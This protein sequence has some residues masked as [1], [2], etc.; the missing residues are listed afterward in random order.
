MPRSESFDKYIA[1]QMK[2]LDF[3]RLSLITSM[4][5]FNDS[6]EEALRRTIRK[7]GIREFSDLANAKVQN[8]SAFVRGDRVLRRHTLDKYLSVFNLKS[9]VIVVE[10]DAA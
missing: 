2:D 7:M 3:A 5:E 6:V 9:K 10:S 8:V 4:E 1:E